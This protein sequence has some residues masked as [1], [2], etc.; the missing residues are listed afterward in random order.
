MKSYGDYARWLESI[1]GEIRTGVYGS[2]IYILVFTYRDRTTERTGV[3]QES[4]MSPSSIRY[5][6]VELELEAEWEKHQ[7]TLKTNN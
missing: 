7:A 2:N 1:G 4:V 6:N 5:L 3:T